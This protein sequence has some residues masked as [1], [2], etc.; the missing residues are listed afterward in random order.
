[1]SDKKYV[2]SLI[3]ENDTN[4]SVE[5]DKGDFL[6]EEGEIE[7][8]YIYFLNEGNV[9][10]LKKKWVMWSAKQKELVGL[11]SFFSKTST[12]CYSVKA[13]SKCKLLKVEMSDFKKLLI[14]DQ[15]F[16][17]A[18]MEMLCDRIKLTNG[19]TKKLLEQPSRRRLIYELITKAKDIKTNRIPYSS[20]DLSELVG[21]SVRLIR[22]MISELEQKKLLQ[23]TKGALVIHDL[24]GL[25]IVGKIPH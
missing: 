18:V 13:T 4:Q 8:E 5:L 20:E 15:R 25:E 19:R 11:A 1:M 3:T 10:V 12:Y 22:N 23:R 21:V 7:N 24:R 9:N 14:K 17:K 16:S 2:F 6:F